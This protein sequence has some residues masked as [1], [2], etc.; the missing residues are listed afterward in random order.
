MLIIT[1]AIMILLPL[2][3]FPESRFY[4]IEE[5]IR[6]QIEDRDARARRLSSYAHHLKTESLYPWPK[7]KTIVPEYFDGRI[8]RYEPRIEVVLLERVP[9]KDRIHMFPY[10]SRRLQGYLGRRPAYFNTVAMKIYCQ[11]EE[12]EMVFQYIHVL[13]KKFDN[14]DLFIPFEFENPL[15]ASYTDSLM[16][17]DC[18]VSLGPPFRER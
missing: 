9:G 7:L 12:G 4:T 11:N 10:L 14:P 8:N 6:I 13:E 3:I 1:T 15:Q 2:N 17:D 16:E 5:P 18:S